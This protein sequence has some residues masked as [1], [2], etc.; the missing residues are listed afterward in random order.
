MPVP[1]HSESGILNSQSGRMMETCRPSF[2]LSVR[3]LCTRGLT[4]KILALSLLIHVD[5]S[6][7]LFIEY[8]Q[9]GGK[10]V[11]ITQ[12]RLPRKQVK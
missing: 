5:L 1:R 11:L 9:R 8:V 7:T 3:T 12:G 4:V 10:A 6:A 2:D